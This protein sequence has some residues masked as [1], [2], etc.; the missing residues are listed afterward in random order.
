MRTERIQ[1]VL[2]YRSP[3]DACLAAFAGGPVAM[4]YSR[5]DP[6]TR[7]EANAE[8]LESI[9]GFR[10]NGCYEIPGEYVVTRGERE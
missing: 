5:F 10:R 9:A 7:D 1:T 4:A 8:Y 3:E 2:E 6:K